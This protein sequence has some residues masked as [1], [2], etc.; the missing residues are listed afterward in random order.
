[1]MRKLSAMFLGMVCLVGGMHTAKAENILYDTVGLLGGAQQILEEWQSD[2][3]YTIPNAV[4]ANAAG[5]MILQ[6][7]SGGVVLG[8][9]GGQAI[10]MRQ[11]QGRWSPPVFFRMRGGS[12]GVQIG[13]QRIETIAFFMTPEALSRFEE[14]GAVDWAMGSTA[15]AGPYGGNADLSTLTG[16]D[17]LVYQ[18]SSGLDIGLVLKGSSLSFDE[19][20]NAALYGRDDLTAAMILNGQVP[21]P[22]YAQPLADQ[23]SR[24]SRPSRW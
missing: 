8:V 13:G 24:Y 5:I 11:N 12:L 3:R 15:V 20:R 7:W 4:Y 16:A 22:S 10:V 6:Q 17:I 2:P 23:L 14:D 18:K 1:M 21:M 19:Q 9:S